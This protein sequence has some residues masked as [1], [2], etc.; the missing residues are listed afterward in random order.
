MRDR[1]LGEEVWGNI[2][3]PA[4]EVIKYVDESELL[5]MFRGFLFT[6]IVPI[7]RDIG[8]WGEK[9]QGAFADMGVLAFADA[10]IDAMMADD[11]Q[12]AD[13][14]DAERDAAIAETLKVG[15][16]SADS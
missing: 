8:L 3:L 2:G 11:E 9:V 14:I 5:R 7:L 12:Q 16:E 6:R 15:A 10:D 13:Q 4:K 1:F